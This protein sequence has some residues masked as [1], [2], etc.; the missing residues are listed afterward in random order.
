[1]PYNS[2][3]R[4]KTKIILQICRIFFKVF[5]RGIIFSKHGF[6]HIEIMRNFHEKKST[7]WIVTLSHMIVLSSIFCRTREIKLLSW[8]S[9]LDTQYK[10]FPQILFLKTWRSQCSRTYKNWKFHDFFWIF[11]FVPIVFLRVKSRVESVFTVSERSDAEKVHFLMICHQ[12]TSY[13]N[14]MVSE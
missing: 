1:M 7:F 13:F 11:S 5:S 14:N 12:K 10:R 8:I 4:C 9:T 2:L 3:R 6:L